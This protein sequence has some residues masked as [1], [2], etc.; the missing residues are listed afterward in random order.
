MT[1]PRFGRFFSTDSAKAVKADRFGYLNAINYAA[2]HTTGGRGNYCAGASAGCKALCLGMYS[3]QAAMVRDIENDIN[4][5]RASRIAKAQYFAD[6]PQA[7]MDEMC[8]HIERLVIRARKLGK[9][10]CV[11]PN[12]STDIPYERIR[13]ASRGGRTIFDVFPMVQFVDYTKRPERFDNP[14]ANLHL[15]FSRSETNEAKCRAILARGHNVAAVFAGAFPETYLGAPV[16][17]GDEHD[18]RHL[19][20]RRPGGYIVGLSPKGAKA[21]R[22]QS[23]FVIRA[24]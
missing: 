16:I 13:I 24:A 12:G 19:D 22:D 11:R 9:A 20:P 3:G 23:G 1:K 10:L 7:Y 15:T 4:S 5:V 14:P 6:E 21:K 18:L 8:F 2:P 17:N